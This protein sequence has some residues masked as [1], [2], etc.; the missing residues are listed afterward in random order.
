MKRALKVSKQVMVTFFILSL[1]F[2]LAWLGVMAFN[3]LDITNPGTTFDTY[4]F[5]AFL[6]KWFVPH[7]KAILDLFTGQKY[8]FVY[9][10]DFYFLL[11]YGGYLG[12]AASLALIVVGLVFA[13]KYKRKRY[14]PYILVILLATAAVLEVT[15]NYHYASGLQVKADKFWAGYRH[16]LTFRVDEYVGFYDILFTYLTIGFALFSYFFIIPTVVAACCRA[17]LL[18]MPV[19]EEEQQQENAEEQPADQQEP[20]VEQLPQDES[21]SFAIADQQ[22]G[23]IVE[24]P[25]PENEVEPEPGAEETMSDFEAEPEELVNQKASNIVVEKLPEDNNVVKKDELAGLLK[26]L[27]RDIVR[28]ELARANANREEDRPGYGRGDHSITGATFG[29]PLVVQYFNGGINGQPAAQPQIVPA[30]QP[31]PQPAPV[32]EPAK[33][34]E[35]KPAEEKPAEVQPAPQEPEVASEPDS[36]EEGGK[37]PIIRIPFTERMLDAEKEMQNDYNELK[38][39][40]LSYGVN[41]RVSNSGDTFRL[42]RKTYVKITIAGKSLKLYFALD[43]QDYAD[44]KM[45]IGDASQHAVYAEIPLIF[46]VKSGLSMRRA[47]ELIRDVMTKDGLEQGEIGSVNWVKELKANAK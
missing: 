6:D 27:V 20:A 11:T 39:E 37:N 40:I 32:Q 23:N 36:E 5:Q 31:Q 26:E 19:E 34:P 12:A 33:Q 4:D 41:S 24:E 7:F 42:H 18:T 30:P 13:F 46:K 14:I 25:L 1:V 17:K 44:S 8:G 22:E 21:E 29:G 16:Y 43:P 35:E 2:G 38:N 9:A 28:D 45:P 10:G 15:A 3:G 47:K